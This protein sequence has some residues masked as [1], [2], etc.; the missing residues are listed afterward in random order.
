MEPD[1]RIRRIAIVGGG[2]VGW[3]TAVMLGRKLGGHC[4]IHVVETAESAFPGQADA[5]LPP[6][7]ELLRF[8]GVDQ[9]DFIDK[10]Q[11]TYSLGARF[12]DWTMPGQSFWHPF[13]GFGALIERRPFYHFWHKGM[14][15]GLKPK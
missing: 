14:A 13:G 10:T 5:T 4:S 15:L 2:V 6:V 8:L 9:D 12:L 7:L 1:R 11:S 3:A